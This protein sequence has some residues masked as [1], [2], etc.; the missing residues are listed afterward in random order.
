MIGGI[1]EICGKSFKGLQLSRD[2]ASSFGGKVKTSE[3]LGS[4]MEKR[5]YRAEVRRERK[6]RDILSPVNVLQDIIKLYH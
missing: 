3:D 2:I 1:F 5:G 4:V 6:K